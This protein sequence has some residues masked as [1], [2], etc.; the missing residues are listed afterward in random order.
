[1]ATITD[2]LL[3]ELKTAKD[4]QAFFNANEDKFINETPASFLNHSIVSKNMTVAQVVKISGST[5]YVYKV[6]N[7]TRKPSRNILIAIAFGMGLSFEELQV[8]FRI[9]KQAILDSRD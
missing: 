3:K 9:S 8:L 5:E 6:F 7:G 2:N 1:M 4:I